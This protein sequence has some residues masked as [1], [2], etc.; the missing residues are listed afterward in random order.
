[1]YKRY[2]LTAIHHTVV[3]TCMFLGGGSKAKI[4]EEPMQTAIP[5]Y[6][7]I[8]NHGALSIIFLPLEAKRKSRLIILYNNKYK[9][10]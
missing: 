4:S 1:M 5:V 6:D 2:G 9:D 7:Q 3:D 8:G 10:I